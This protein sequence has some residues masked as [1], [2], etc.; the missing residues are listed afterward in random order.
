LSKK[1]ANH[2]D[3]CIQPSEAERT[4]EGL[5]RLS[6]SHR[7]VL[8][9]IEDYNHGLLEREVCRRCGVQRLCIV[10]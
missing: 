4:L 2:K 10:S 6:E 8:K 3:E 5:A 9:K 1:V 7:W